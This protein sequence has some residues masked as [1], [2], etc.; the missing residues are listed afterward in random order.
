MSMRISGNSLTESA[1]QLYQQYQTTGSQTTFNDLLR[2]ATGDVQ[3]AT[4]PKAQIWS[5][6]QAWK[7]Q[8]PKRVLPDSKGATEENLT[9][10]LEHFTGDKRTGELSLF[11]RIEVVDTMREM[12]ILT[13]EEMMNVLGLGKSGLVIGGKIGDPPK[14]V[15][16]GLG[17]DYQMHEWSNVL[18]HLPLSRM[19]NLNDLFETVDIMLRG[20]SAEGTAAEIREVLERVSPGLGTSYSFTESAYPLYQNKQ[21][22]PQATT[23]DLADEIQALLDIVAHRVSFTES[24]YRLYQ[25]NQ[26]SSQAKTYYLADAIQTFLD[27]RV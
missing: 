3:N 5:D 12:G 16:L 22:S 21:P 17:D 23:Y 1:W 10:L 7:S 19:N 2:T 13:Q 11:Q 25:N 24:A 26:S 20:I 6:Y 9:Y 4:D 15:Y 14:G 18:H 8:Q 27:I